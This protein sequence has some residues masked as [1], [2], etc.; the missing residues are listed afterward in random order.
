MIIIIKKNVRILCVQHCSTRIMCVCGGGGEAGEGRRTRIQ[1]LL[2]LV[3]GAYLGKSRSRFSTPER[4][5]SP[6]PREVFKLFHSCS[7]RVRLFSR[8]FGGSEILH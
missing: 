5:V 7:V 1:K 8:H 2:W 6:E 3:A 4:S